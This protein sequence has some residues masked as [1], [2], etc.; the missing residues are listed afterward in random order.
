MRIISY[1]INGIRAAIKK[2][3]LD[4]FECDMTYF[5]VKNYENYKID[6][7]LFEE[8]GQTS[9]DLWGTWSETLKSWDV[10]LNSR[11]NVFFDFLGGVT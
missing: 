7:P 6:L 10:C 4:F 1:N 9:R 3:F 8:L 2:G 11:K 5:S